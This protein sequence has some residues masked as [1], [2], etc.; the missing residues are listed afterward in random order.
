MALLYTLTL[1][2][3]S[4][5]AEF[6]GWRAEPFPLSQVQLDPSSRFGQVQAKELDYLLTLD[7]TRLV[8]L[9]LLAA[10]ISKTCNP[11]PHTQYYGHFIG[12]WLSSSAMMY[13]NTGNKTLQTKMNQ[14]IQELQNCETA[15]T[16]IG[17]D[18]YLFP[19][20]PVEF[21]VL[22]GQLPPPIP[23]NVPYYVMHKVM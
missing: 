18:G 17:Y 9:Y 2:L 11:Y 8:C 5:S 22:E 1:V 21:Q 14:I 4:V 3:I 12:H 23:V 19:Y 7:S 13:S 10:N 20:S 6:P 15:W 16:N